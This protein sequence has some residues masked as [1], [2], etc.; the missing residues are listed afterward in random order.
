MTV[1]LGVLLL[2]LVGAFAAGSFLHWRDNRPR[3]AGLEELRQACL[4]YAD[5]SHWRRR[6]FHGRRWV[7]SPAD[8]DRGARARRALNGV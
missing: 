7:K 6:H 1:I 8:C 2:A 3:H 5:E 4:W